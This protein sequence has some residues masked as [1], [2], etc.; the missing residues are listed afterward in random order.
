[1]SINSAC[2]FCA[3]SRKCDPIY[4]DAGRELGGLLAA[5]GITTVTGGGSTGLMG[6][7]ADGALAAGGKVIGV[8]PHFMN[9]HEVAHRGLS[10]LHLVDGMHERLAAMLDESEAFITLPGGCG[11]L[12]EL[13][14]ILTRKRLGLTTRP[15]I[16]VNVRGYFDPCL[17]MLTRCISEQF[18]DGRHASMWTVVDSVPA[19]LPAIEAAPAWDRDSSHFAVP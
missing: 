12:E 1:M 4:L 18:M 13:F 3:S 2:V 11:T 15:L 9:K 17:D 5:A 8:L 14:F 10:R 19:V 6:S 7:V 16:I